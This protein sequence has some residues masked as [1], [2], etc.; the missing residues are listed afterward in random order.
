MLYNNSLSTFIQTITLKNEMTYLGVTSPFPHSQLMPSKQL[1]MSPLSRT[2]MRVGASTYSNPYSCKLSTVSTLLYST[3]PLWF[4]SLPFLLILPALQ[5]T[6]SMYI[7]SLRLLSICTTTHYRLNYLHTH[8]QAIPPS[9]P[10][11]KPGQAERI[12]RWTDEAV[13][14]T[15]NIFR[16]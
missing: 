4:F 8:T 2:N 3:F 6:T 12:V 9:T 16:L 13:G 1:R 10:W 7:H 15:K 11:T 14:W 5:L